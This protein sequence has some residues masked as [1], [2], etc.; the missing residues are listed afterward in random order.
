MTKQDGTKQCDFLRPSTL[1]VLHFT[2]NL[3]I[4]ILLESRVG[5]SIFFFFFLIYWAAL[6]L[7]A[8]LN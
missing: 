2:S 8:A 7:I 5:K 1:N 3:K 4:K 6:G